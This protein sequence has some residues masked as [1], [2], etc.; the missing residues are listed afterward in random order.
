MT[1]GEYSAEERLCV[2]AARVVVMGSAIA[3]PRVVVVSLQRMSR[4]INSTPLR[5]F[6]E[7]KWMRKIEIIK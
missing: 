5:L 1:V 7:T 4:G 6:G 3:P 2:K